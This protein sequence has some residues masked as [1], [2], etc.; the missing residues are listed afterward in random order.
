VGCFGITLFGWGVHRL[1]SWYCMPML[2]R[3]VSTLIQLLCGK[4]NMRILIF[5]GALGGGAANKNASR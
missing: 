2:E 1:I 3:L 5:A 4:H